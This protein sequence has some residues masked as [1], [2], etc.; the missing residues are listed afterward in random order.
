FENVILID[1]TLDEI[2][3]GTIQLTTPRF[4]RDFPRAMSTHDIGLKDVI[5]GMQLR[6]TIPSIY[7]F[8]VSIAKI[9]P[10]QVTLSPEINKR[11]PELIKQIKNLSRKLIQQKS[12][13]PE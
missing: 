5:E 8:T 10:M 4:S 3:P 6:E 9:Q 2:N 12:A 11:L 13:V 7:L 1:A